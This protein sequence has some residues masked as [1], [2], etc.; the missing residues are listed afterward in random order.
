MTLRPVPNSLWRSRTSRPG[1]W[2]RWDAKLESRPGCLPLR[3]SGWRARRCPGLESYKRKDFLDDALLQDGGDDLQ[4]S[5]Q[6]LAA[7]DG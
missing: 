2:R 7:S 4:L 5:A 3:P 1:V 6:L